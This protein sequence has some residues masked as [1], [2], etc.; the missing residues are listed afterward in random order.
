MFNF[1]MWFMKWE[2]FMIF[3]VDLKEFIDNDKIIDFEC[4]LNEVYIDL[5]YWIGKEMM[6]MFLKEGLICKII[7]DINSDF[8]ECNFVGVIKSI[9]LQIVLSGNCIM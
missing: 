2:E 5:I 1:C 4:C 9:V 6:D 7:S 3:V 8:V